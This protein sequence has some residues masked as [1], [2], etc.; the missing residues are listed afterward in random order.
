[1]FLRQPF[2]TALV[3]T[4]IVFITPVVNATLPPEVRKEL[5]ELMKE[6]KDV[7]SLVKKKDV[8]Q[9][10]A[11]IK[12]AEDRITELAIADD[13]K[14]RTYATFKGQLEKAKNVIPVSFEHEVAPILKDNCLRCH[15]E[16]NPRANLRLDTFNGI[17]KGGQ[18]G[19][20][21][22]PGLPARSALVLAMAS[23]DDQLRMP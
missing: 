16:E 17:V 23:P 12:K 6:L 18:S 7:N 10:K 15:G 4:A 22:T 19:V 14:D 1:M 8:D 13:E 9:A 5:S 21:V 3:L 20:P 2:M 11:I